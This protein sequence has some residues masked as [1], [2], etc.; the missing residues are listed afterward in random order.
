MQTDFHS[1]DLEF[2][3]D[4]AAA[5]L[6]QFYDPGPGGFFFTSH[7]H[8]KLIHRPKPGYDSATPSGNGV[9]ALALQRLGHITGELRYLDAAARTLQLFYPALAQHPNG[10][11]SLLMAL[12][13][14]IEPPRV[15]MLRGPAGELHQWQN[16]L[17][18]RYLSSAL[19]LAV[20]EEAK[21]LSPLL[22]KPVIRGAV[23]AWV[24]QGVTCLPPVDKL[25]TLLDLLKTHEIR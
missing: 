8:E 20:S 16:A 10:Y 13:E 6:E 9:A 12:E 5:L 2:A 15:V 4:L 22:A 25:E 24:C 1:R 18:Q 17:S 21:G 14:A 3:E 19:I 23:N 7:D 11:T